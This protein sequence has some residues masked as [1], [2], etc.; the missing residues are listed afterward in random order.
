MRGEDLADSAGEKGVF[1]CAHKP[2]LANQAN[3]D[4]ADGAAEVVPR[5]N[6][7]GQGHAERINYHQGEKGAHKGKEGGGGEKINEKI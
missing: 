7:G 2:F 6:G 4:D 3:Q 5:I 1:F